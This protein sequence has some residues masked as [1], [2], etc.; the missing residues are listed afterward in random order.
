MATRLKIARVGVDLKQDELAQRI[1]VSR[2]TISHWE[3]GGAQ[4]SLGDAAALARVTG[5]TLDWLAGG[6]ARP[7]G[8]E[9]PTFWS[10]VAEGMGLDAQVSEIFAAVSAR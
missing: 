3:R 4:P 5:V 1:G 9:P 8:F 6:E 7:E 10:V 2:Q